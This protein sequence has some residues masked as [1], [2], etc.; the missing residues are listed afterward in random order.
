MIGTVRP[1]PE[2][3]LLV[4]YLKDRAYGSAVAHAELAEVGS[5]VPQSSRY[6]S[7]VQRARRVLLVDWQ[8][9]LETVAGQGYRL[10]EPSEF[11][12]RVRRGLRLTGRRLRATRRIAAS[13]PSHLLTDEQNCR[14]AD[15]QAKT[16]KLDAFYRT[17]LLGTRPV[18]PTPKADVPKLLTT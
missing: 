9:E 17:V 5:L 2:W 15:I 3:R 6:F 1:H 8:R 14:M 18:L 7:Q 11:F 13:A 10:V 4:E 16:G 12:G